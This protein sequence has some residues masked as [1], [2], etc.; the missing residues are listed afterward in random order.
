MN[1]TKNEVATQTALTVDELN[2]I[3]FLLAEKN[4][5]KEIEELR[6]SFN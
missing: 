5:E 1:K 2:K 4:D 3:G 6:K